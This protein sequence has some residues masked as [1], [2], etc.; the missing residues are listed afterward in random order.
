MHGETSMKIQKANS[1]KPQ[2]TRPWGTTVRLLLTTQFLV[3]PASLSLC[4]PQVDSQV[5][6][7]KGEA[8]WESAL[9]SPREEPRCLAF[10]VSPIH[11]AG[12][13]FPFL[14]Y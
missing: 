3:L 14:S 11:T 6:K 5:D 7:A 12:S 9:S 2:A 1:D 8:S 10:L 4:F 13:V